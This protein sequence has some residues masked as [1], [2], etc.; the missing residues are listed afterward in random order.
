MCK[1]WF[2]SI[3]PLRLRMRE[4]RVSDLDVFVNIS[5]YP[6]VVWATDHS[7]KTILTLNFL[8]VVFLQLLLPFVGL[9]DKR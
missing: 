9:H 7:L 6:F 3:R 4:K 1:I 2:K 5:I 8:N